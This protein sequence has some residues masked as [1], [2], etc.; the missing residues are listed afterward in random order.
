[1][2][3]FAGW[4]EKSVSW[5][6]KKTFGA[7]KEGME[8]WDGDGDGDGGGGQYRSPNES[9]WRMNASSTKKKTSGK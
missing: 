2:D 9:D 6:K 7:R 4:L 5:R 3:G 8:R 1:M